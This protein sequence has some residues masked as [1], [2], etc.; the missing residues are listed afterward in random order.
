M[1][2]NIFDVREMVE[3]GDNDDRKDPL[4]MSCFAM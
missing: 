3:Y 4:A 2:P 1:S